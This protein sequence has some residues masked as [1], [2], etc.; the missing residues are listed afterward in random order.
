MTA[1]DGAMVRAALLSILGGRKQ[2]Q[3]PGPRTLRDVAAAAGIHETDLSRR[4][5]G[6]RPLTA[7]HVA[8]L[9]EAL[10]VAPVALTGD[11]APHGRQ[12]T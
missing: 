8:E 12:Q 11:S 9:A 4:L 1:P 3:E 7:D 6:R 5:A 2:R 10:G